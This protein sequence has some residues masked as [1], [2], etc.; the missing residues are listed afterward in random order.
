MNSS[1]PANFSDWCEPM[2]QPRFCPFSWPANT[3]PRM[4]LPRYSL[5]ARTS[6]S[7]TAWLT[8]VV[9]CVGLLGNVPAQAAEPTEITFERQVRSIFRAHCFDCH[10][11]TDSPKGKLDLRQVRL[12]LRGG[13][14]G[15]AVEPGKPAESLLIERIKAGEMPPGEKKVSPAELAILEQ[16]IAAGAKTV[17]PEPETIPPGVGISEEERSFWSFQPIK[18]PEVPALN[19]FPPEARVRTPI[20]ALLLSKMPTGLGFAPDADRRTLIRRAYFD[21]IGLPP[22][23][24]EMQRWMLDTRENWFDELLTDLLNSEHYGERWGRH[25]LDVAGYAD[26]DGGSLADPERTWAWKYR[27]YVIRSLNADLPFD[28]FIAEQLAGDELAGPQNGDL[29]PDQTR[30]LTATGF[31][32]M[33]ADGTGSGADNPEGRNQVMADTLKIVGTSLL[34]LSLQCAQCHDH[35]YDPIPQS[36]YYSLRAVFEPALDWKAWRPPAARLVSQYTQADRQK[37]AEVEKEVA[38]I[39]AVRN[40]KQAEYIQQAIDKELLKFEEPLR[41]QLKEVVQTP[42]DKRTAEQKKLLDSNPSLKINPGVLYQYLPEAA[43]EL[44]KIDQQINTAR[45]KRPPE[46]FIP[47]LIEPANHLPETRLFYRGDFNQPKETLAPAGL[48]VVAPDGQRVPFP[49][50]DPAR[51]TSGRRLAL[52]QWLTSPSQ[53]LF[54]RVIVN[55][56]W[57]HHFGKGI[58]AT[59]A[60]FGV[61]GARPSHPELLD[62]LADEFR[63]QGWSLKRLHRLIMTST[64]WRQS[65][66]VAGDP[67]A[68][69]RTATPATQTYARRPLMRLEAELIRDRMLAVTGVLDRKMY[70]WPIPLREDDT[71]QIIV[72][73]DK[74]RRSLYIQVRRSRPVALMQA[75]DAPVMETNC[76][77]RPSST[78]A[79]QSLMLLNGDF[80]L[81]MAGKLADRGA[82]EATPLPAELLSSIPDMPTIRS[83]DWEYGYGAF[84][85]ATKKIASFTPLPHFNGSTWQGGATLPDPKLGFALLHAQGGHPDLP[86]RSVIRRWTA[87]QSG[88]VTIEGTLGH[89]SPNGDGVR[90]RIVSSR[91]GLLG[92][93][94]SFNGQTATP[95]ANVTL[96]AGEKIDFVVDSLTNITSDSFSWPV[97]LKYQPAAST[98]AP[99]PVERKISSVEQFRGPT[100]SSADLLAQASRAF[101]LALSRPLSPEE[102]KTVAGFLSQQVA[103]LNESPASVPSGRTPTRQALVNLCQTLLGCNEF[104]YV[105]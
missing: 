22:R 12:M 99:N 101:E 34:G 83:A 41:A 9:V 13:E 33:A 5:P 18:R 63:T 84:D 24:E 2:L 59:P 49:A 37:A 73:P 60:D 70:E 87:S 8:G 48:S 19:T 32:R 68:D 7:L 67:L 21:L 75:F 44:K 88:T 39:S 100:E 17:R 16:W 38:E 93:W 43:E 90:G 61:L 11:A 58:V 56:V 25:W 10:G 26:S 51:A 78:V 105:D 15:P 4:D 104:L 65:C 62:W 29:T 53:P 35:R 92:E 103:A 27:D 72:D 3:S 52:A 47:A 28:R 79:T 95:L 23:P 82:A 20:D 42:D 1:R 91:Q 64:A 94:K 55:R 45:N 54:P 69:Q 86:E 80:I 71:G 6:G 89:G 66:D 102:L 40:K 98:A 97:T 74:T 14:S 36:D 77:N 85:E 76:E 30:L 57:M 81:Q 50:K 96:E 31:L 46:E